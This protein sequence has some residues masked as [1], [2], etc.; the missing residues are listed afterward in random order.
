MAKKRKQ[1]SVTR[2]DANSSFDEAPAEYENRRGHTV[3]AVVG[4]AIQKGSKIPFQWNH[5]KVPIGANRGLFSNYIGVIVRERVSIN[6][7][8]WEDVPEILN[9]VYEF[10]TKGFIV[11]DERKG[12]VLGRASIIWRS[13]KA[14][15]R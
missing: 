10:I 6:Y 8:E 3:L 9:E 12:Y 14:I 4:K 15:L 13:Y 2:D 1:T 11:P 7:R 5:Y